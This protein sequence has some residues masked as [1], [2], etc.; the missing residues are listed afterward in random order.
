M[1]LYQRLQLIERKIFSAI[2]G[3]DIKNFNE[4][5]VKKFLSL[6]EQHIKELRRFGDNFRKKKISEKEFNSIL[7][8]YKKLD[9]SFARK[10][11]KALEG[12]FGDDEIQKLYDEINDLRIKNGLK[13]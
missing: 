3:R 2:V 7:K 11:L 9:G 1:N 4:D 5:S 12:G 13:P 10:I 8:I 6:C